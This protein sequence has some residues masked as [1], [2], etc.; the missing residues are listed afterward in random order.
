MNFNAPEND[1]IL[2]IF[3]IETPPKPLFHTNFITALFIQTVLKYIPKVYF[4]S[5][6]LTLLKNELLLLLQV[7]CKNHGHISSTIF[8]VFNGCFE[9][10][11]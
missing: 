8:L 5:L 11:N 3:K 1:H 7:L 10:M 2:P 6:N 4:M 9:I